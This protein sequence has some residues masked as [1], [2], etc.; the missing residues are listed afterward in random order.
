[1]FCLGMDYEGIERQLI[2]KILFFAGFTKII[3]K[4]FELGEPVGPIPSVDYSLDIKE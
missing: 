2:W 4:K 1:M 3:D